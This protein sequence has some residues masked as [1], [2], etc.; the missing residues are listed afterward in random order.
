MERELP[1][2]SKEAPAAGQALLDQLPTALSY[3]YIRRLLEED[4]VREFGFQE[5][6]P[7]EIVEEVEP[8]RWTVKLQKMN[9]HCRRLAVLA[10]FCVFWLRGSIAWGFWDYATYEPRYGNF[11]KPTDVYVLRARAALT[12][13]SKRHRAWRDLE[14]L[15]ELDPGCMRRRV[16]G[17]W[18]R[19]GPGNRICP[20]IT[21]GS[22]GVFRRRN[23]RKKN[24]R[25]GGSS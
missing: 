4:G 22:C 5:K 3:D 18:T 15:M 21:G 10:A 1:P 16:S 11:P 17:G 19:S 14:R 6:T 9:P 12:D 23:A 7:P 25:P 13:Y 20:S 24:G 2:A 8:H